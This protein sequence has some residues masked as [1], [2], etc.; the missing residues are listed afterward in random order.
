MPPPPS[1]QEGGPSPLP[2]PRGGSPADPSPSPLPGGDRLEVRGKREEA[3]ASRAHTHTHA[4]ENPSQAELAQG[5]MA[6]WLDMDLEERAKVLVSRSISEI[7]SG[8][9]DHVA[10]IQG[11]MHRVIAHYVK[12]CPGVVKGKNLTFA[13]ARAVSVL[14]DDTEVQAQEAERRLLLMIDWFERE[15]PRRW[16]NGDRRS[17]QDWF[18]D[19][20][21]V[22]GGRSGMV[23]ANGQDRDTAT[24]LGS[25]LTQALEWEQAVIRRNT[26]AV[27]EEHIPVEGGE[28]W[29]PEETKRQFEATMA[30]ID[31]IN[32]D[33]AL[34]LN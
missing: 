18:G 20:V 1:P 4:R 24:I 7:P 32:R 28:V 25:N 19:T 33:R 10:T 29:T 14:V 5:G 2:P 22:F 3:R 34:G 16:T 17:G 30:K 23:S 12:K 21:Q 8:V 26:R 11:V 6:S 27:R 9:E 13:V 15:N 31:K